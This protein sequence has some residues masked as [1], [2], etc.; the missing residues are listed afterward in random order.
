MDLA[1]NTP[2]FI[3][4]EDYTLAVSPGIGN[5]SES[6]YIRRVVHLA[7]L[8]GYRVAV[9]NHV[10]VLKC[11]PLTG[12]RMFDY[13]NTDDYDGM[14]QDLVKRYPGTKLICVGFSM[15]GNII[16]KYLGEKRRRPEGIVAGIS[17][18]QGYDAVK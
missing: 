8:Q 14:V 10:G 4:S 6:V 2:S 17:A 5:T 16:T 7:Q 3:S 9:L 11:V 1:N 15:G 13:G 12:N 18:C